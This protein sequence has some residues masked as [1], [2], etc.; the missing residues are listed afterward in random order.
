MTRPSG[1]RERIY[2]EASA[3]LARL[4]G[5]HRSAE[6]EAALQEWL[7]ADVAHQAAFERATELWDIL[8][9]AVAVGRPVVAPPV[10]R[11][12]VLPYALA[13][14]LL[15]A[16][17][18]GVISYNGTFDHSPDALL[19]TERGQQRVTTLGDGS[20]VALNTDSHVTVR[21][22]RKERRILLSQGEV[23]FDVAHDAARPFIV[24]AGK[25]QIRAL[26]TAFVV[27]KDG[28]EVRVTLLR[29]RVEVRRTGEEPELMAILQPGDRLSVGADDL[30]KL[31]RPSL[32]TIT[33]WQR[34]E[35]LFS[36][37]P[38]SEAVAEVNRY[39]R[40][41]VVVANPRLAR[42]P[43]SGVFSTEDTR[44]FVAAVA[45][46]HGLRVRREADRLL[47]S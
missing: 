32:E 46:L 34:G 9:G 21:F 22:A 19:S 3:W 25:E 39:G 33:A 37:T 17:G 7:R 16:I 12:R 26:G 23:M 10:T 45:Q 38:L 31:D 36:A 18:A 1:N 15:A 27:R 13:A 30:P 24:N 47:I 35:I 20:R 8:P 5:P 43:I 40:L 2:A 41:Q 11:R 4:Q 29:G 28:P 44:E 6:T 42:L 14:S